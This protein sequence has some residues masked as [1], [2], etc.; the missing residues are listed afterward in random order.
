MG[1]NWRG[2]AT[3]TRRRPCLGHAPARSQAP[4][5]GPGGNPPGGHAAD[6][7]RLTL[8][9]PYENRQMAKSKGARRPR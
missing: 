9:T 1:G 5:E 4:A 2:Q 7:R 8:P 6:C 3:P